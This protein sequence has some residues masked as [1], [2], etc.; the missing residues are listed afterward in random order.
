MYT[1]IWLFFNHFP[2]FILCICLF[3]AVVVILTIQCS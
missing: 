3:F 1:L 2:W